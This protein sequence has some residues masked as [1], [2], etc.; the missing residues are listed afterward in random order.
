MLDTKRK[1]AYFPGCSLSTSAKENNNSLIHFFKRVGISLIELEDWNCCGSSSAHS[2][3]KNIA[4]QLPA[5][6]LSLVPA[7]QS[8]MVA[9]PSCYLR[10]KHC[11]LEIQKDS[12]LL[13]KYKKQFGRDINPDLNILHFFE[14]IDQLNLKENARFS[15]SSLNGL[16]C[17]PYYGCMLARPPEMRH[18]KNHYGIMEGILRNLGAEPVRWS[19]A[20]RCC[21]TFLSVVRP[22]I[23]TK[24]VNQIIS[25]SILC[26]ADCIVTACAMCHMNIEM[27]CN[28]P[29]PIPVM[30]FSELLS[31]AIG[32]A[33][34][35]GWFDRHLI[36]P[37]PLLKRKNI[38]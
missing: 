28:L 10:L 1:L 21:G 27:R 30:H 15:I 26:K 38:L 22:D 37:L 14:V 6:N 33:P 25:N 16:R 34:K 4:E 24:L 3:N 29:R 36:D 7:G 2:T 31:L 11:Q 19:Y 32:E 23:A 20:S 17:A 13:Q 8:L 35:N 9:C 5:R 18:E 12:R